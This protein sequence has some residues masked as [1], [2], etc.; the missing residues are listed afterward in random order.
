MHIERLSE[1]CRAFA[2]HGFD[3]VDIAA[4]HDIIYFSAPKEVPDELAEALTRYR[5]RWSDSDY[6]WY[7]FV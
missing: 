7:I 1:I 5:V 2:V 6:S 3:D 4:E